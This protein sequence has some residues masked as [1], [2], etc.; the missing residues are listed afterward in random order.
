[1][2]VPGEKI[3]A[4]VGAAQLPLTG[5]EL[6]PLVQT[7]SGTP[8]NIATALS[9]WALSVTNGTTTI[10]GVTSLRVNGAISGASPSA[11]LVIS[12]GETLFLSTYPGVDPNGVIDSRAAV[13]NAL[14]QV[15][16]TKVTLIWDC[17]A[18]LNIGLNPANTIFVNSYTNVEFTPT[19]LILSDAVGVPTFCFQNTHDCIWRNVKFQYCAGLSPSL[20]GV[21]SQYSWGALAAPYGAATGPVVAATSTFNTTQ[22]TNY[23]AN[24]WGNIF[25]GGATALW[26]GPTNGG[27]M[28]MI[29][30]NAYRLYFVGTDCR[31]YVPDNL[32]ACYFIPC[33][34]TM[35]A[36][37]NANLTVTNAT[38]ASSANT[39]VPT[40]IYFDHWELDGVLMGFVGSPGS[41]QAT[42]IVGKR[43]SDVQDQSGGNVGGAGTPF[44]PPHLI[45][46]ISN[47]VGCQTKLFN[48]MDEGVYVGTATRRSTSSGYINSLKCSPHN[49]SV[50]D[51]YTSLRPDGGWQM[52][53]DAFGGGG[54]FKNFY[55]R[56]DTSVG[57]GNFAVAFA[58]A[59]PLI[60]VNIDG[61]SLDLATVAQQYPISSATSGSNT[62]VNFRW[63]C[64]VQDWPQSAT[65]YPGFAFAGN[66]VIVK[67]E[68][69]FL[70][71][72]STQT[73]RGSFCNQ[74]T[75]LLTQSDVDIRVVGWRVVPLTFTATIAAGATSA[76]L[77]TAGVAVTW[78]YTSGAYN[79]WFSDNEQRLVTFTNGATTA[80]WTGGITNASG[81]TAAASCSLM[82]AAQVDGYK[83]RVL[84]AQ[85]GQAW[86]NKIRI[87][88]GTSGFEQTVDNGM[89]RETWA[90]YWAG[91]PIGATY[92][93]AIVFPS[94]FAIDQ[95]G[96]SVTT[97]L[98]TTNGLTSVG[99][100]WSGTPTAL[101]AA[102]G[103]TAGT[104]PPQPIATPVSLGGS[105][106]Q[107]LL[108]PTAG[109]FGTTGVM[110]VAVRGTRILNAL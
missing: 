85:S 14:A 83:Q 17:P 89:V 56:H 80:T 99:V 16:N 59:P 88:D 7:Q 106:R 92:N 13:V 34:V 4:M 43:Y 57:G 102:A 82:N 41:W 101:L 15:A 37:W 3:S 1:M 9:N 25:T 5:A 110:Q 11:S 24:N 40:E 29:R 48:T 94:T 87:V 60:D 90:Q 98:D 50:I 28:F 77:A 96:Y 6:V 68:L 104:N 47:Y 79:V 108:T 32:L 100:G 31:A 35:D 54:S 19:G 46:T 70:N 18:Y 97:A 39:S 27:A 36:Q 53:T 64:T 91:T 67:A 58:G 44:S 78:P 71:C 69:I 49:G 103:I 2:S 51:G 30:G 93:T 61:E 52:V 63:R 76:T 62:G 84:I 55:I 74:G 38:V 42:N 109:T 72:T 75:E 10:N 21:G 8:T 86:G 105:Q 95:Y 66:N 22:I 73:L 26:A 12:G 20:N 65:Y 81:V 107:V 23:L 33:L 45:Y